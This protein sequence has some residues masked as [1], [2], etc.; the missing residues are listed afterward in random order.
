VCDVIVIAFD[1]NKNVLVKNAQGLKI[2]S[3]DDAANRIRHEKQMAKLK[4]KKSE[5]KRFRQA[6]VEDDPL[7]G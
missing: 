7:I 1:E 3:V 4:R 2:K 5:S 6:S